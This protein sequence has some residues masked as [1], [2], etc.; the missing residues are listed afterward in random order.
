MA[1][2]APAAD[3]IGAICDTVS[4]VWVSSDHQRRAFMHNCND[5]LGHKPQRLLLD[6]SYPEMSLSLGHFQRAVHQH[7]SASVNPV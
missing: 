2:T 4:A 1:R 5:S 6:R 7:I 3:V